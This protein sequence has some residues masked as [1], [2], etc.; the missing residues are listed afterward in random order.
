MDIIKINGYEHIRA[1][2]VF[3]MRNHGSTPNLE[4]IGGEDPG[5]GLPQEWSEDRPSPEFLGMFRTTV[6]NNYLD[7]SYDVK[8]IPVAII[9]I[10]EIAGTM[11]REDEWTSYLSG[12]GHLLPNAKTVRGTYELPAYQIFVGYA[13]N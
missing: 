12:K 6:E 5:I 11:R 8:E 13:E 3:P 2:G 10:R 9:V 1:L 4:L 7:N